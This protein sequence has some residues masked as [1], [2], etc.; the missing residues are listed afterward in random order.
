MRIRHGWIY[1][2]PSH[3]ATPARLIVKLTYG[4]NTTQVF[5]DSNVGATAASEF[6]SSKL[7]ES[8]KLEDLAFLGYRIISETVT[9]TPSNPLAPLVN[10]IKEGK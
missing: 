1:R 4:E 8:W 2:E 9:P 3:G 6:I 7:G 5:D 10:S